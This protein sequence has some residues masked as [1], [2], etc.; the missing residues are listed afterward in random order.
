MSK[1]TF[2][3]FA[4]SIE[5]KNIGIWNKLAK[6]DELGHKFDYDKLKELCEKCSELLDKI[7]GMIDTSEMCSIAKC[8]C[9][10]RNCTTSKNGTWF[11]E[12][13]LALYRWSS[14]RD[15]DDDDDDDYEITG[16]Y[17]E[18]KKLVDELL[19][20]LDEIEKKID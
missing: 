12:F 5:L 20:K 3:E 14:L 18:C 11:H 16:N 6:S 7:D 13:L 17:E 8:F 10:T 4:F 19:S 9:D 1:H 15:P 2:G